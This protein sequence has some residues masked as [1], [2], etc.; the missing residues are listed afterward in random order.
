MKNKLLL[1][2]LLLLSCSSCKMHSLFS[3]RSEKAVV[4]MKTDIVET[5]HVETVVQATEKI[6]E[7]TEIQEDFTETTTTVKWSEPDSSGR[8]FPIETTTKI[9][10][11]TTNKKVGGTVYKT[12][13]ATSEVVERK[14]DKSTEKSTTDIKITEKTKTKPVTPAWITWGTVILSLGLLVLVY[15]ILKRYRIIK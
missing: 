9:R 4:E 8:Q 6:A 5:S 7:Q 2:S 13:V 15:L 12:A 3:K 11:S 14:E 1:L 10:T